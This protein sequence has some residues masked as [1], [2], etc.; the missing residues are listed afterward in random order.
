MCAIQFRQKFN[1]AHQKCCK[2][3]LRRINIQGQ[4][5]DVHL[6]EFFNATCSKFLSARSHKT[7]VYN[8]KLA[9]SNLFIFETGVYFTLK[10]VLTRINQLDIEMRN[11][12]SNETSPVASV[13]FT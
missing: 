5:D 6:Q 10:T 2:G 13:F 7:V 1:N 12:R 9:H 8:E 3:V 4:K 11:V